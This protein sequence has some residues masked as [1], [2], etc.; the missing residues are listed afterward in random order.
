VRVSLY[1]VEN[2]VRLEVEDDGVGLAQ[3]ATPAETG[4]FGAPTDAWRGGL[5]LRSMR[6]RAAR[7]GGALTITSGELGGV[8]IRLA[9]PAA[10][11]PAGMQGLA[12]Q[13]PVCWAHTSAVVEDHR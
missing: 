7:L 1:L 3:H 5:G 4:L 10:L 8:A 9:A 13:E 2:S 12:I 11:A 6:E